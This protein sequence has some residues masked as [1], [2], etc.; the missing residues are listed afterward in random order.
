MPGPEGTAPGASKA[1]VFPLACWALGLVGFSQLVIGGIALAARLED[2]KQVRIVEKEVPKL[3]PVR[4][5]E[6]VPAQDGASVVARPPVAEI[7]PPPVP[8]PMPDPTPIAAPEIADPVSERLVRDAR[9]ARIAGDMM[10][11]ITKLDEALK[12]SPDDPSVHYELGLVH[13]TM[14]VNDKAAAHFEKVFQLGVSGAG[15]LYELAAAKL[16][17]GFDPPEGALGKLALG[18]VRI[19]R[20]TRVEKG[21]RVILTIPIQK[22]PDSEIDPSELSVEVEFFN[23][24]SRGEIMEAKDSPAM[25]STKD[26]WPALPF[27]FAGGEEPL[28]VTYTI[29][30]QEGRT[31]HLFGQ[32]KYYGQIVSL[33]YRGEILD[34]AAWPRDLSGRARRQPAQQLPLQEP[35]FDQL[36]PDIG[37]GVLPPL[38]MDTPDVPFIESLPPLP[39]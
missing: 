15:A 18:R 34:V 26:E 12:Q 35:S 36:P 20:D 23:R 10:A 33:F 16:R 29:N 5:P 22:S 37:P 19:F 8:D 38:P 17:D 6:K 28:R 1:P 32:E 11:A 25:E 27:D 3:I 31:E 39:R 21:E 24:N 14:G 7:P 9:K 2:S 4:I 30:P 13:E